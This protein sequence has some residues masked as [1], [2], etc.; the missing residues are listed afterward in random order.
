MRM[1]MEKR[2]KTKAIEG[3]KKK[4]K[5]RQPN[6]DYETHH[7]AHVQVLEH[8]SPLLSGAKELRKISLHWSGKVYVILFSPPLRVT[9]LGRA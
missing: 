6:H 5:H 8:P 1:R 2:K 9:R 7:R 3:G 4:A